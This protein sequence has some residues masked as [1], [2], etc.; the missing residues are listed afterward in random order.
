MISPNNVFAP[1]WLKV[2]GRW[3]L[4]L[5]I[6][7]VS[8]FQVLIFSNSLWWKIKV[9]PWNFVLECLGWR[10]GEHMIKS[11]CYDPSLG[12]VTKT[13]AWKN[14]GRECN[15]GVTF[16][17]LRVQG[18]VRE[19]PHTLP[20]GFSLWELESQWTFKPLESDLR[21]QNS[22]DWIFHYNIGKLLRCRCLKW[23]RMIHLSV[24]NINYCQKKG[25]KSKCQFDSQPLQIWNHTELRVCR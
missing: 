21:G 18:S 24:Y 19:W 9:K 25:W 12:L 22:L 17:L 1:F 2:L 10:H 3:C 23:S 15:L 7:K 14:V 6:T 20:N 4:F 5:C 13:R 16:T 8:G 11:F